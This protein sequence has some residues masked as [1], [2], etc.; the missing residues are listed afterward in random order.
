[1]SED[2]ISLYDLLN[3]AI[4]APQQVAVNFSALRSLLLAVLR[5]LD[6]LEVKTQWRDPPPGDSLKQH[7]HIEEEQPQ[8]HE[9]VEQDVQPGTELQKRTPSSS[10]PTPTSGAAA[11]GQRRLLT[12]IQACE[13]GVSKVRA[14]TYSV[15]YN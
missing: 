9:D 10:A 6:T 11:S 4:A 12:R 1:M 14:A 15:S 8:V 2:N 3:L 7:R 13:D 5:Q